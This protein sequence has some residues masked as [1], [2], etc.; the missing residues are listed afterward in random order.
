MDKESFKYKYDLSDFVKVGVA[1][2]IALAFIS[3][4]YWLIFTFTD[5][6]VYTFSYSEAKELYE[7]SSV[8]FGEENYPSCDFP[9]C[10]ETAYKKLY[11]DPM[12]PDIVPKGIQVFSKMPNKAGFKFNPGSFT[13]TEKNEHTVYDEGTYL[14]P[15]GDGSF[16]IEVRKDKYV[17]HTKG[18]TKT[19]SS[20]T[21]EGNYCDTH[22]DE[23]R[24]IWYE[25]IEE[26][27]ITKNIGYYYFEYGLWISLGIIPV[28]ALIGCL[29]YGI[30]LGVVCLPA[31]KKVEDA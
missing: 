12:Y 30:C 7:E 31:K 23:A 2:G 14:V 15:Q 13:Y 25:E 22:L 16:R 21:Y 24:R 19:V 3:L 1:I 17:V 26:I 9:G 4:I 8:S 6:T 10:D 20:I 5:S 11:L 29:V 28:G 18:A 27:F